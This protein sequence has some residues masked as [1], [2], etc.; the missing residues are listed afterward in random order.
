MEK[1][2]F[3][4]TLED[5]R[6][7]SKSND[8]YDMLLISSLVYK[9]LYDQHPL[10]NKV[11]ENKTIKFEINN[12]KPPG[13]LG[14]TFWSVED[15]IDPDTSAP[16]LLN[17]KIVTKDG[18]YTQIVMLVNGE[19]FTIKDL[20][21]FLRNK[22]GAVHSDTI[23]LNEKESILKD[24]QNTLTIGGV[25]AGLRL[26]RAISRIVLKALD[27]YNKESELMTPHQN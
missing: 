8:W 22:Q 17:R 21:K 3:N 24:I 16:R 23:S 10:I 20:I 26:M 15:G 6:N 5:L 2:L 4:K 14:L 11:A 25:A 13:I 19:I 1:E 27:E 7:K 9:L 18:L 12:R